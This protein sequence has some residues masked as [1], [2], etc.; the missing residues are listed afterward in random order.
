MVRPIAVR[1]SKRDLEKTVSRQ[2]TASQVH[3]QKGAWEHVEGGLQEQAN[4]RLGD[5]GLLVDTAVINGI[6]VLFFKEM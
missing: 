4:S 5:S 2:G 3:V 1:P 6:K